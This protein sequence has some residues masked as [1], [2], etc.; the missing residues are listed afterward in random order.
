MVID[1]KE[2]VKNLKQSEL[3]ITSVAVIEGED[4][5]VY[6]TEDWD[7][8]ADVSII[9]SIWKTFQKS[10]TYSEKKY[11]VL[12]RTSERLVA[13]S[14]KGDGSIVGAKDDEHKVI[15]HLNPGGYGPTAVMAVQR[16]V[17]SMSSQTVY[18]DESS[19][20][21]KTIT[22]HPLSKEGSLRG[23]MLAE[24]KFFF[25]KG[26]KLEKPDELDLKRREEEK[27]QRMDEIEKILLALE[28]T[29]DDTHV[30]MVIKAEFT[31]DYI[32]D[33]FHLLKVKQKLNK[34]LKEEF[35]T[36]NLDL[37]IIKRV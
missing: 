25:K 33:D 29:K 36:D 30:Y 35:Q 18:M 12:Q 16:A 22:P 14:Y 15:A 20:L 8:N 21:G 32:Y 17:R 24:F 37:K 9:L 13:M 23:Q 1:Y 31:T 4:D 3:D 26:I 6:S 28:I 34:L 27:K 2:V 5:I 11:S 10:I 7:I 19:Q